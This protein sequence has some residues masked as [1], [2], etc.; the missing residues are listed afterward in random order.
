[1]KKVIALVLALSLII[2][3]AVLFT[4]CSKDNAEDTTT[5][6]AAEVETTLA[7]ETTT[8]ADE[9]TTLADE[10]T[11]LADETTTLAEGESTSAEEKKV[12]ETKEEILA[13][14]TAVMNQAKKD[15]PAFNKIE[16]Q[17]LPGDENSR[18][19]TKGKTLVNIVLGVAENFFTTEADAT[20]EVKEKGNE[21]RSWPLIKAPVG[22]ALTDVSAIK[23]A[24]CEVLA[25]GNYRITIVLNSEKNPEPIAEGATTAP[26]KT[27]AMFSPLSKKDIDNTLTG[28]GIVTAVIK[29][30][31]YSLTYHDCTAVLEY[32]PET[33]HVVSLEQVMWV[34]ISGAGKVT[35]LAFEIEKQELKNTMKI[36]NIKY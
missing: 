12:P 4:S 29:D 8:L 11:T 6:T 26:S 10:T 16:Y 19:I 14:Y 2:G 27:G 18:V 22:C 17:A 3:G 25:N 31:T 5:T 23:S 1:M 33:N 36:Y 9:T 21:M 20:V 30:V 35:G 34:R 13:A 28:D 24:K 7:D 15:A 32:N